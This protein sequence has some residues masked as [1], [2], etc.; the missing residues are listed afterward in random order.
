MLSQPLLSYNLCAVICWDAWW[1]AF[2]TEYPN[3]NGEISTFI[4]VL[5]KIFLSDILSVRAAYDDAVDR[6]ARGHHGKK[7]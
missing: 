6:K 4:F 7:N 1:Y 5:P 3:C 2:C